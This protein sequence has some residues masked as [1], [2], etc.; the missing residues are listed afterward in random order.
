MVL[1]ENLYYLLNQVYIFP[2]SDSLYKPIKSLHEYCLNFT[3]IQ[4]LLANLFKIGVKILKI[5]KL[6]T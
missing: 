3:F 4:G 6:N 2:S 1:E 5:L